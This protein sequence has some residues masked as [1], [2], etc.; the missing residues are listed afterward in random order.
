M[1]VL[2]LLEKRFKSISRVSVEHFAI[3]SAVFFF[4]F[5]FF[6]RFFACFA[7]QRKVYFYR[8]KLKIYKSCTVF[9]VVSTHKI[10]SILF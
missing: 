8:V 4:F 9:T 3:A 5:F 10:I 1:A 6:F 2:P 7:V